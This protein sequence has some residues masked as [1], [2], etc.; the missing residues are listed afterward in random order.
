MMVLEFST[1]WYDLPVFFFLYCYTVPILSTD[2]LHRF[3]VVLFYLC[4]VSYFFPPQHPSFI[5][6][7]SS[8]LRLNNFRRL[9]RLGEPDYVSA[10]RNSLSNFTI[11]GLLVSSFLKYRELRPRYYFFFLNIVSYVPDTTS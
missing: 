3:A 9:F 6:F 10:V 2:S 11:T 7:L 4:G 1:R 5:K 8:C